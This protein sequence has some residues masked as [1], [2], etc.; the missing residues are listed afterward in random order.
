MKIC[1]II[2]EYNPL[3]NGHLYHI[4]K[5][6]KISDAIIVIMSGHLM[7]R[8]DLAIYDKWS[9]AKAALICGADIVI[10]LPTTFSCSCAERFSYGAVKLLNDLNCVNM[11]SFGSESGNI[12]ELIKVAKLCKEIDGTE[13]MKYYL[14]QGYSY[15]KA[16]QLA[17]GQKSSVLNFPNN[18]LGVEYIKACLK[19]KSSISFHT[20]KRLGAQHNSDIPDKTASASFLRKNP[21]KLCDY[22]PNQVLN[23]YKDSSQFP[24]NLLFYKLRNKSLSEFSNL[25][26][27][28]EGLENRL[29]KA[30]KNSKNLDEFFKLAKT[31]RY[32]YSRLRRI[33]FYSLM[34]IYKQDLPKSPEYARVLG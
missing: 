10:E 2:A 31:K 28:T 29:F 11:I 24:E 19:I 33:A 14:K 12:N 17:I 4:N 8:G 32:T 22:V 27:V 34:D 18:T 20:I 25:P 6:K 9:R 15:P 26:D 7:Q 30:S 5:V 1:G 16:R 21:Q 3:H 13:H 23:L